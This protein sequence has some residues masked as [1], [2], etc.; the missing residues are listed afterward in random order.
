MPHPFKPGATPPGITPRTCSSE[1]GLEV[2]RWLEPKFVELQ[3]CFQA[4]LERHRRE[5][6]VILRRVLLEGTFPGVLATDST[7]QQDHKPGAVLAVKP[8]FKGAEDTSEQKEAPPEEKSPSQQNPASPS[9]VSVTQLSRTRSDLKMSKDQARLHSFL[10]EGDDNASVSPLRYFVSGPLDWWIGLI[11]TSNLIVMIIQAEVMGQL[12]DDSFTAGFRRDDLG[13]SVFSHLEYAFWAVYLLDLLLRVYILRKEWYFQEKQGYMYANIFDGVLVTVSTFELLILPNFLST[14]VEDRNTIIIKILK[15]TRLSRG[16][17]VIR[18]V[19]LFRQLKILLHTCV[20]SIGA[21]F[22]SLMLL[23]LLK[24][25]CALVLC[26]SLFSFIVDDSNDRDARVWVNNM[27]GSFFKSMYTMFEITYSGGWP[28]YARPVIEMVNPWYWTVFVLY[29]VLVIFAVIRIISALFL[30]ETLSCASNDA[31]LAL[32]ERRRA[33]E[34][35]KMKLEELFGAADLDGDGCIT[36]EEFNTA[37]GNKQIQHYLSVLEIQVQD[38]DPLFAL[39]D[40]GDQNVTIE[41]FV[42]GITHIRGNARALDVIMLKHDITSIKTE[43]Q[44]DMARLRTW[45]HP[46]LE[47]FDCKPLGDPS[48]SKGNAPS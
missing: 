26:Q 3:V 40:D 41:E 27:Y 45:L 43:L 8:I 22:W 20:A 15:L 14:N 39:L 19:K 1:T 28:N 36:Q 24:M 2:S 23:L 10:T 16:L 18:T 29:V 33:A 48:S 35:Y 9:Q 7:L 42:N 25:T 13:L 12:A 37:L 31:E 4:E 32:D 6:D 17:R 5:S 21:L 46:L 34:N 47:R 11:V 44:H 30:K 38:V